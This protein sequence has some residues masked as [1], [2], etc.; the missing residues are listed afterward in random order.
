MLYMLVWIFPPERNIFLQTMI[1]RLYMLLLLLPLPMIKPPPFFLKTSFF[2]TS[3]LFFVQRWDHKFWWDYWRQN[4]HWSKSV[5]GTLEPLWAGKR[6]TRPEK[7]TIV[8]NTKA[9]NTHSSLHFLQNIKRLF[10]PVRKGIIKLL[11]LSQNQGFL[12]SS[13]ILINIS[14]ECT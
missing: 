12:P 6:E 1:V 4:P 9:S 2:F 8:R 10:V 11:Q 13:L 7:K 14:V 5:E 3:G